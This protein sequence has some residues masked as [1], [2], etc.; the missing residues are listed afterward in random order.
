MPAA[1]ATEYRISPEEAEETE[2]LEHS[3]EDLDFPT[4]AKVAEWSRQ[5]DGVF[6]DAN[7]K[8]QEELA[9]HQRERDYEL[10]TAG[11]TFLEDRSGETPVHYSRENPYPEAYISLTHIQQMLT[12]G[13]LAAD[14]M[15]FADPAERAEVAAAAAPALLDELIK[16]P[17]ENPSAAWKETYAATTELIALGLIA[18]N[19][20]YEP[21]LSENWNRDLL[22]KRALVS[23]NLHNSNPESD[24]PAGPEAFLE[25]YGQSLANARS[26]NAEYLFL[27]PPPAEEFKTTDHP[28]EISQTSEVRAAMFYQMSNALQERWPD[29][30]GCPYN[31]PAMQTAFQSQEFSSPEEFRQEAA[32]V[33]KEATAFFAE[34]PEGHPARAGRA[35]LQGQLAKY[36]TTFPDNEVNALFDMT[37]TERNLQDTL[38]AMALWVDS[39][40]DQPLDFDDLTR[41]GMANAVERNRS[42]YR[43]ELPQTSLMLYS[44]A[45]FQTALESMQ[46][47]DLSDLNPD[48]SFN[49]AMLHFH[50]DSPANALPWPA[51]RACLELLQGSMDNARLLHAGAVGNSIAEDRPHWQNP[52][53]R[54]SLEANRK[55][56]LLRFQNQ[57][58]ERWELNEQLSG[59]IA[60]QIH[61]GGAA[62]YPDNPEMTKEQAAA[63]FQ[64]AGETAAQ[65]PLIQE[66][67]TEISSIICRVGNPPENKNGFHPEG[68]YEGMAEHIVMMEVLLDLDRRWQEKQGPEAVRQVQERQRE[69]KD[70]HEDYMS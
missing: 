1:N 64:A 24:H 18:G 51:K 28:V 12:F 68:Q 63:R 37:P 21:E 38:K 34:L 62:A 60:D 70:W 39:P 9:G 40:A 69:W 47:K 45:N 36:L 35:L 8:A 44:A 43:W 30:A 58:A 23:L 49:E 6:A 42:F 26:G 5:L 22:V 27:P 13:R 57:A 15:E 54:E 25:K 67:L 4:A 46:V 66:R 32:A 33:A 14:R 10:R 29:T 20:E 65:H 17:P 41:Q 11:E 16:D 31:Y 53:V 48:L 52:E 55:G 50:P 19:A 2:D 3:S 56:C 7:E 59:V 61:D